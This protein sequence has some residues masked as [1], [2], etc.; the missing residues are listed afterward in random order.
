MHN[1]MENSLQKAM[2][3]MGI[4]LNENRHNVNEYGCV[5]L[6]LD[7][8]D[9][10][11]IQS[12]IDKKDLYEDP[13]DDSYGLESNCHV[14]ILYGLHEVVKDEYIKEIVDKFDFNDDIVSNGLSLFKNEKYDVLKFDVVKDNN[15]L[16]KCNN[17]LKNLPNTNTFPVYH[18]HITLAYL[19]RGFGKK[20]VKL[21]N[22]KDEYVFKPTKIIYSKI[23]GSEVNLK[24]IK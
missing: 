11:D 5:M 7:Y 3:L 24:T 19:K 20:Y 4:K 8:P 18:P 13:N 23:D 1:N 10:K 14:T 6:Y 12:K 22:N 16:G 17:E 21:L 2:R 9:F 15:D